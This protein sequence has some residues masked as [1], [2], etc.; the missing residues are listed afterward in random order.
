MISRA[1][2]TTICQIIMVGL[3]VV[4]AP[5]ANAQESLQSL[6]PEVQEALIESTRNLA[7]SAGK[8]AFTI[9]E[10]DELNHANQ[11]L[12]Q[13]IK[14]NQAGQN[15][16]A[17]PLAQNVL[18][19]TQRI[20]GK[21]H[22]SVAGKQLT[23]ARLLQESYRYREALPHFE[24]CLRINVPFFGE[25]HA[26]I[27]EAYRAYA[28]CLLEAGEYDKSYDYIMRALK[29]SNSIH[30]ENIVHSIFLN[31][32]GYICRLTLR[33]EEARQLYER[34]LQIRLDTATCPPDLIAGAHN[35]YGDLLAQ[36]G[37]YAE[38]HIELE[39]ALEKTKEIPGGEFLAA[40]TINNLALLAKFQGKFDEAGQLYQTSLD[41]LRKLSSEVTPDIAIRLT[42]LGALQVRTG[43]LSSAIKNLLEA[44]EIFIKFKGPM[45]LEVVRTLASLSEAYYKLGNIPQAHILN[46]QRLL[47]LRAIGAHTKELGLAHFD[48]GYTCMYQGEESKGI[49]HLR[50]ALNL[51]EK[52]GQYDNRWASV[53]SGTAVFASALGQTDRALE[54]FN[55]TQ[56]FAWWRGHKVLPGLPMREQNTYFRRLNRDLHRAVTFALQNSQNS[57]VVNS[58]FEWIANGKGMA[59]EALAKQVRLTTGALKSDA[60]VRELIRTRR[61]LSATLMRTETSE[62]GSDKQSLHNY[63][64]KQLVER[65]QALSRRLAVS[66]G[67]TVI[68]EKWLNL[69]D[70]NSGLAAGCVYVDF[71]RITPGSFDRKKQTYFDSEPIYV[72]WVLRKNE[73]PN[74]FQ[75][76]SASQID[77]LI[78]QFHEHIKQQF[79]ANGK[80]ADEAEIARIANTN[81]LEI[82]RLIV[83]PVCS[84]FREG[85]KLILS[86]DS[87][88]W[89]VPWAALSTPDDERYLVEK[90]PI[91]IVHSARQ[92]SLPLTAPGST[93]GESWIIA[94]PA[95]DLPLPGR[96][97]VERNELLS[98]ILER[99]TRLPNTSGQARQIQKS[100]SK[101]GGV[102]AKLMLQSEASEQRVKSLKSPQFL[103]FGTHAFSFEEPSRTLE[104]RAKE[105]F[106]EQLSVRNIIID[107]ESTNP[108]ASCGLLLAGCNNAGKDL[109]LDFEDGILTGLEILNI[110]LTGTDLV[111][112][113][114]CETASG[115]L[116]TGDG[117]ASLQQAFH[118]AGAKNVA[119]SLWSVDDEATRTLTESFFRKFIEI[120]DPAVAL[121]M[122]QLEL[123][124]QKREFTQLVHPYYWSAMT[125][126]GF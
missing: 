113:A 72:A 118:V 70:I 35:N 9:E 6:S 123:L 96:A 119:G 121:Q 26:E 42:N 40:Q 60:S 114:A 103:L 14:L 98:P 36:L 17:I 48:F 77:Q 105:S 99:V 57:D 117:I 44:R 91:Q 28:R 52:S 34:S 84:Q 122:A 67:A 31:D 39:T 112:L 73:S 37:D 100:L 7:Q 24:D 71:A 59:Q 120:R 25:N 65:E 115:K 90:H 62:D 87:T 79:V 20:M 56:R 10:L 89:L 88:L 86:P 47:I 66:L 58:S 78:N 54:C 102:E 15:Q 53:Q 50:E 27:A 81:L 92:V 95:F 111:M 12:E 23:L 124:K 46:H 2:K 74:L 5:L 68:D 97:G 125:V 30:G 108:F 116:H 51:L 3:L 43:E 109:A 75:L 55:Q 21:D 61:E 8:N 4:T 106:L 82:S 80:Q 85:E 101:L 18:A 22:G 69:E 126:S 16:Q 33:Y 41:I 19:I 45:S 32:A 94:N 104:L 1:S 38:A 49:E 83:H 13:I 63:Q 76:G 107:S 11:Q 64:V 93:K 29:S 110:D